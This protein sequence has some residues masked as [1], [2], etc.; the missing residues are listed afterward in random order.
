[1]TF[2]RARRNLR[3]LQQRFLIAQEGQISSSCVS[4]LDDKPIFF[5][6]SD[7]GRSS[8]EF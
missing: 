2:K 1:V 4:Q 5:S 6:E 8:A 7:S 3:D